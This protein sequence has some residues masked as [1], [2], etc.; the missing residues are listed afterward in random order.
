MR[1]GKKPLGDFQQPLPKGEAVSAMITADS[2][3]YSMQAVASARQHWIQRCRFLVYLL[4]AGPYLSS[5]P[6]L[7][8][9]GD[10]HDLHAQA[11]GIQLQLRQHL[12]N[13]IVV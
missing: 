10:P 4:R 3:S 9:R 11:D 6:G 13:L 5:E 2:D 8:Q 12:C 7:H 1:R